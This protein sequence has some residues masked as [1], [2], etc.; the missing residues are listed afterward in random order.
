MIYG[1]LP[2]GGAGGVMREDITSSSFLIV[3]VVSL[4]VLYPAFWRSE[5]EAASERNKA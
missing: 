1:Q 5:F 4:I 2:D 3:T